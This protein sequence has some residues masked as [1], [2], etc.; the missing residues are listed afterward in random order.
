MSCVLEL[1]V[2]MSTWLGC[3]CRASRRESC[4]KM[5]KWPELMLEI[6]PGGGR[7]RKRRSDYT[8]RDDRWASK[9][10]EVQC[11][12]PSQPL[13]AHLKLCQAQGNIFDFKNCW[14][15]LKISGAHHKASCLFSRF[16]SL[17]LKNKK[18]PN[19]CV[20]LEIVFYFVF[21]CCLPPLGLLKEKGIL[22]HKEHC[23]FKTSQEPNQWNYKKGG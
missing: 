13:A 19:L 4:W 7:E 1:S 15:S 2:E 22:P 23:F 17:N 5:S 16:F 14:Q 6:L 20:V 18:S 11:R 10:S 3:S 8:F 21:Y 12:Y 9:S